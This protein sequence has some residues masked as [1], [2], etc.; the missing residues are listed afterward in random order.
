METFQATGKRIDAAKLRGYFQELAN[1]IP[2]DTD[3][4]G[5]VDFDD[6]GMQ[7]SFV[8][9]GAVIGLSIFNTKG[10]AL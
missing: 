1:A 5:S 3:T 6:Y 8:I 10:G 7:A 2:Q 9:D 4:L